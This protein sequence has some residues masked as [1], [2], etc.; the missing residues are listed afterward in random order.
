GVGAGANDY[1]IPAAEFQRHV[2]EIF[3]RRLHHATAGVRGAGETNLAHGWVDEQFFADHAARAGD[4]VE[5]ALRA[6][7]VLDRFIDDLASP[8]IGQRR[9]A[10]WLDD[11]GV[12]R[13]ERRTELIPHQRHRKVP[14]HD[15]AAD[16]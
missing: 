10:G 4:N 13:E 2:F 7:S 12:A 6:A 9:R 3:R 16:A 5:H 1:R 14:W 11:A 15:R 8:E